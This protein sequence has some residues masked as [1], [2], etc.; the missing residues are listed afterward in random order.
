MNKTTLRSSLAGLLMLA[1]LSGLADVAR[2]A[3]ASD[4][5]ALDDA[6]DADEPAVAARR[7]R[8]GG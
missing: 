3:G 8:P 7:G 5:F 6:V 1:A 2:L 4:L